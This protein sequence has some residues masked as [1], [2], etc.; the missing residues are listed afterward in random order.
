MLVLFFYISH[1][2]CEASYA[3]QKNFFLKKL[4]VLEIVDNIP[5]NKQKGR[6]VLSK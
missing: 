3:S 6:K 5:M 4:K 1:K 2:K